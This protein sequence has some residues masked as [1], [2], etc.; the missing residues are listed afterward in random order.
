MSRVRGRKTG[1]AL[2]LELDVRRER[3]E[4]RDSEGPALGYMCIRKGPILRKARQVKRSNDYY[5]AGQYKVH[6]FLKCCRDVHSLLRTT[7]SCVASTYR[8][9]PS[10]KVM[11]LCRV[12]FVENL[13]SL[14][15][16][17]VRRETSSWTQ[18]IPWILA[19]GEPNAEPYQ[20]DRSRLKTGV[21]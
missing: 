10:G 14:I 8:E 1:A 19:V 13:C 16:D 11:S 7:T 12:E 5:S 4:F 9:F 6:I 15:G 20:K 2:T 18:P 3:C 21:T 17:L